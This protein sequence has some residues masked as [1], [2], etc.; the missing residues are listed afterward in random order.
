MR[1]IALCSSI[2]GKLNSNIRMQQDDNIEIF[3]EIV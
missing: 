1:T 2:I 3:Q